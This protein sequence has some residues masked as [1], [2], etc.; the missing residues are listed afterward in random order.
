MAAKEHSNSDGSN[1]PTLISINSYL[2]I[3]VIVTLV[4]SS[5]WLATK[6]ASIEANSV[7][8]SHKIEAELV[9]IRRDLMGMQEQMNQRMGDRWTA[10]MMR[11]YNREMQIANPDI[12]TPSVQD[13]QNGYKN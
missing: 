13:I 1:R 6:L 7:E 12:K 8:R 9:A 4:G 10:T 5:F 2:S 3:G 11:I